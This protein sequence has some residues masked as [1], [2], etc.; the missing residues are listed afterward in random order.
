MG[1]SI[2]QY[3]PRGDASGPI[4]A[5]QRDIAN[6][7]TPML[8]EV[9]MGLDEENWPPLFKELFASYNI[10]QDDLSA[11]VRVLMEA[12]THFI[13]DRNVK[14]PHDAFLAAGVDQLHPIVHMAIFQRLGEV[15][16]GG[17]FI[18]LRDVTQQGSQSAVH[19]DFV[20]ML[21]AGRYLAEKL[22]DHRWG[23]DYDLAVET[24]RSDAEETQRALDQAQ[25]EI[26]SLRCARYQAESERDSLQRRVDETEPAYSRVR[27]VGE[28]NWWSRAWAV[29][30]IAAKLYFQKRI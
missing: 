5:P 19:T 18:A 25:A 29:L 3:R 20:D 12:H 21:A 15:M 7:Y 2:H 6:I 28:R 14:T 10:T 1:R 13:R 17:F 8:R 30:T 22:S 23:T 11:A 24:A 27:E 16:M 26:E 4:Y 9:M